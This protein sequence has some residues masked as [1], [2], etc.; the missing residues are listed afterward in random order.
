MSNFFLLYI[1][2]QNKHPLPAVK[3]AWIPFHNAQVTVCLQ[4]LKSPPEICPRV[5]KNLQNLLFFYYYYFKQTLF[6]LL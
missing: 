5:E 4:V 2:L 6:N 3:D 1:F